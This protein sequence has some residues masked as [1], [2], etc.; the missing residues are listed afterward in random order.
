M[1][2]LAP[3]AVI[4]P[5]SNSAA[6]EPRVGASIPFSIVAL[7]VAV[8]ALALFALPIPVAGLVVAAVIA[9]AVVLG[10]IAVARATR[11]RRGFALALV[12]L[13]VA[14]V[15]GSVATAIG[16]GTTIA[17]AFDANR[18]GSVAASWIDATGDTAAQPA[19]AAD[20]SGQWVVDELLRECRAGHL[21]AVTAP[22]STTL[23]LVGERPVS[24]D[25]FTFTVTV[26]PGSDTWQGSVQ[27]DVPDG[28]EPLSGSSENPLGCESVEIDAFTGAIVTSTAGGD[29]TGGMDAPPAPE[30]EVLFSDLEVGMCL[31]DANLPERFS[32]IPQ[33]DCAEPHDSEVYAIVTLPDG[34]Y[35][36]D[37]E[38]FRL[39]D[40]A[41]YEE[42]EPY[43]GTNYDVS[44][45]Y[46]AYYW[47]DKNGWASGDRDIV[48]VVYDENG[49]IEGSVR[50]SGR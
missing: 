31:N 3:S 32:S 6:R 47:P 19:D 13:G 39:A 4:D 21:H 40:D 14:V 28:S 25:D 26:E 17:F 50:G 38:L 22:G 10:V 7:V 9:V 5:E 16:V 42:Y 15:T 12:A 8:L 18:E 1:T 11:A 23:F 35:P 46:F 36:S 45:Y 49:Q 48:C 30:G 34:A 2:H 29:E 33:V 27:G 24:V 37:D 20:I 41:C 44:Y 43:V